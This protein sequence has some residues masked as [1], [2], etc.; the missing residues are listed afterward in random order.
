MTIESYTKPY[1]KRY[2]K[3]AIIS[4]ED[5]LS[6][7]IVVKQRCRWETTLGKILPRLEAIGYFLR[8]N[9]QSSK[10]RPLNNHLSN[11]NLCISLLA[12]VFTILPLR[13]GLVLLRKPLN[14]LD[15]ESRRG[16][17]ILTHPRQ[18]GQGGRSG[19]YA[20][21][22]EF[23]GSLGEIASPVAGPKRALSQRVDNGNCDGW[24]WWVQ[25]AEGW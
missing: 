19:I 1:S 17:S 8:R 11:E 6:I 3:T 14:H 12:R 5:T 23:V 2:I 9:F 24:R 18:S 15:V 21:E 7:M 13:F 22:E 4:M 10:N 25:R 20:A 16:V